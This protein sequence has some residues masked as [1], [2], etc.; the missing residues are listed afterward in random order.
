MTSRS[1][2]LSILAVAAAAFGL[3]AAPA[4][5]GEG[6]LC[7]PGVYCFVPTVTGTTTTGSRD[8]DT[9][10]A[11]AGI[12]WAF[13]GGPE[14]V[15]G[16]RALRTNASHKVAGAR[17]EATFPFSSSKIAFDKLRLRLVGGHRSGMYEL[18]GGYTFDSKGFVLSSALQADHIHVGTDLT[19]SGYQWQP[20]VGVNSL[21]RA[22]APK[23]RQDGT[24]SCG[25]EQGSLTAVT[26]VTSDV[27]V[28]A[29]QQ[30]NGYTCLL[31]T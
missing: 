4:R 5:A 8:R 19:L 16:V 30:F 21:G 9:T 18:G 3:A 1:P 23:Q 20:F 24:L 13:G 22:K 14:L 6:S 27:S 28:Q 7:G 17:L 2:L 15:V 10:Q 26:D 31:G 11:F 29:H 25:D 12:N